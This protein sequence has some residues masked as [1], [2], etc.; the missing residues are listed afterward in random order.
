[1]VQEDDVLP[2]ERHNK[3][4]CQQKTANLYFSSQVRRQF[5]LLAS[6]RA[7]SPFWASEVSL[8]RKRERGAEE[9]RACNDLS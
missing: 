7:S 8:A 9:R 4:F 1:M 3:P 2:R 6:L 5:K